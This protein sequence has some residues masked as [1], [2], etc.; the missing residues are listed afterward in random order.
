[1]N[2]GE[3]QQIDTPQNVY[4]YPRNRFVAEFVGEP[5]MNVF[6][7]T[8]RGRAGR[9]RAVHDTFEIPLPDAEGVA[10][11]RADLG[12]RPE[13]L[14]LRPDADADGDTS[15]STPDDA[16]RDPI[17]A[18][19]TVT[20]PLGDT[21]LLECR[22]GDVPV[23]VQV[24]PDAAVAPDDRVSLWYDPERLHLFDPETGAATYHSDGTSPDHRPDAP[25]QLA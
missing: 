20:E 15:L 9:R 25:D 18:T 6:P 4:D 23:R 2:D 13:H 17:P 5:A 11:G 12:I 22:V 8:V 19:V 24:G 1:M 3:I 7:V 21:L 14:S 16:G 10:D